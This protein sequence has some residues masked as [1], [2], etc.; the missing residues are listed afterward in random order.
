MRVVV[1]RP[2]EQATAIAASLT[3]LGHK[4]IILPLTEIVALP[5]A[6]LDVSGVTC[7]AVTSGNALRNSPPGLAGQVAGVP[8]FAVGDRTADAAREAGFEQVISAR[9]D[10]AALAPLVLENTKPGDR[11]LYLC[12][13]RRRP[14]FEEAMETAGREVLLAETYE[15]RQRSPEPGAAKLLTSADVVLVYAQSAAEALNKMDISSSQA[16]FIC[17]SERVATTLR[18]PAGNVR[19]IAHP[20]ETSMLAEIESLP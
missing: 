16:I 9:G 8:L 12:G 4:A 14:T 19:L 7:V 10:V 1:T 6:V 11:I 20:D 13:R 3:G 2:L 5:V 18:A 15:T 17:M